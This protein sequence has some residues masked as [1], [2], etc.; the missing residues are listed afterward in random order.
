MA[1]NTL[2][3][4]VLSPSTAT[5]D[6]TEKRLNYQRLESLQDYVLIAQDEVNIEVYSHSAQGWT[7]M[8]YENEGAVFLPSIDLQLDVATIYEGVL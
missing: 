5:I 3:I 2:I 1:M 8:S 4:E 6:R 7:R